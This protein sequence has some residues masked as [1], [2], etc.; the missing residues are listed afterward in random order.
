MARCRPPPQASRSRAC[1]E[2]GAGCG[3]RRA[4]RLRHLREIDERLVVADGEGVLD[5]L[6][7]SAARALR[8]R[9]PQAFV[10][11]ARTLDVLGEARFGRVSWRIAFREQLFQNAEAVMANQHGAA[12]VPAAAQ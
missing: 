4:P 12:R 7:E 6:V 2:L 8:E 5:L 9:D 3:R 1:P 10:V 11:A